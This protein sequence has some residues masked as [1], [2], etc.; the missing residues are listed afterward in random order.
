MGAQRF[1]QRVRQIVHQREVTEP[2]SSSPIDPV[3]LEGVQAV[4]S[5]DNHSASRPEHSICLLHHLTIICHMLQYL[6]K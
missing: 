2:V 6:V 1:S 5:E 3:G 4:G